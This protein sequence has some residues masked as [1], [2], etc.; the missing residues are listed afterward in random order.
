[1][2]EKSWDPLGSQD[3]HFSSMLGFFCNATLFFLFRFHVPHDHN[4]L[5]FGSSLVLPARSQSKNPTDVS[6]MSRVAIYGIKNSKTSWTDRIKYA[7][8][9]VS[10]PVHKLYSKYLLVSA[11]K[12]LI[13]AKDSKILS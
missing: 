1:M 5:I 12:K 2:V 7:V 3:A 4:C 6:E 10:I 8:N 13:A 11:M 9:W